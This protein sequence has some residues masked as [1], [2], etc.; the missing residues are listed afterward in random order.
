MPEPCPFL[1]RTFPNCSIIRS[2]ETEGAAIGVVRIFNVWVTAESGESA[3]ALA[4]RF[5]TR[6][7]Q[8]FSLFPTQAL[9]QA[10]PQPGNSGGR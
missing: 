3:V 10:E 6:L 8:R 9:Y 4:T 7:A 5:Q 1:S 2:T